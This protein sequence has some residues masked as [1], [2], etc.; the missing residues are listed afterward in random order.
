[1]HTNNKQQTG[2]LTTSQWVK[3]LATK[4]LKVSLDNTITMAEGE[5]EDLSSSKINANVAM[6]LFDV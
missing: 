1:M 3:H 4:E 2:S 6:C 5:S